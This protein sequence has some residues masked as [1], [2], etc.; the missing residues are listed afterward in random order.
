MA[1]ASSKDA[2]EA[3]K[4]GSKDCGAA[5]VCPTGSAADYPNQ[6]HVGQSVNATVNSSASASQT[7]AQPKPAPPK[8]EKQAEV[9]Q[10][11]TESELQTH[12]FK[13]GK[14]KNKKHLQLIPQA[15]ADE[16]IYPQVKD[17]K[18]EDLALG[19]VPALSQVKS[20]VVA[21]KKVT[22]KAPPRKS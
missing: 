6:Q 20:K 15:F 21:A 11:E 14:A 18:S 10:V 8:A 19:G 16:A 22:K 3:A 13:K 9:T 12:S 7:A 4:R 5:I 2:G 17:E 1:K